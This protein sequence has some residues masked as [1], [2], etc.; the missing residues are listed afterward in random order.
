MHTGNQISR[1]TGRS[2]R[3]DWRNW[4]ENDPSLIQGL[5]ESYQRTLAGFE[6]FCRKRGACEPSGGGVGGAVR[7]IAGNVSR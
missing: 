3:A 7:P 1:G 5:R 4:L 6:Q 2:E